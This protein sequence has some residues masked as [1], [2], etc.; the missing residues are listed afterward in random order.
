M[1][2]IEVDTAAL[3]GNVLNDA[4]IRFNQ[5]DEFQTN[6]TTVTLQ[7]EG[8]ED[9][10]RIGF[11]AYPNPTD[12]LLYVRLKDGSAVYQLELIDQRG[13]LVDSW[14]I[15]Q[16]AE[17]DLQGVVPGIYNLRLG[18]VPGIYNL[19]L[20]SDKVVINKKLVKN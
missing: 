12:G 1:Y 18:V 4:T 2:S 17:L 6:M 5:N 9:L 20:G 13:R 16:S 8:I 7:P 15:K 14:S 3:A 10:E 19:R 11:S